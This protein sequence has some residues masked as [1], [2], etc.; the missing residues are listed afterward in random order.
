MMMLVVFTAFLGYDL[1]TAVGTSTFIMTFTALIGFVAHSMINPAIVLERW[2]VLIICI[3]VATTASLISAR[4][5]NRVDNKT[6]G[7][8]TGVILTI[9]GACM[10]YLNY[11]V[12]MQIP[13]VVSEILYTLGILIGFLIVAVALALLLFKMFHIGG[14]ARRKIL[15]TISF[16]IILVIML[17]SK[18]WYIPAIICIIFTIVVYPI[19]WFFEKNP[20]YQDLF[21]QR[22]QG[23][24]KNSLILLFGNAT[25]LITLFWGLLG[26][27]ITVIAS[28]LAWG[29][30]DEAAALIGKSYGKHHIPIHD[31]KKTYEGSLAMCIV[32]FI[33]IIVTMYVGQISLLKSILIA[34]VGSIGATIIEAI[35]IKGYDTVTVPFVTAIIIF[36]MLL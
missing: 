29:L 23:E 30:G 22:R 32:A 5:A 1:K 20:L 35:S 34:L 19:L 13:A 27:E 14:E 21:Q 28:I 9:L 11:F 17:T 2:N 7:L 31:H 15:H 33:A 16:L 24:V 4:F 36:I 25:L 12:D 18:H 10:I 3:V 8:T 26:S 6:V